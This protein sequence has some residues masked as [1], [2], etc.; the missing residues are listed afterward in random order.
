MRPYSQD[1]RDRVLAA[2]D[3]GLATRVV[4]TRFSVRESWVRRLKQRRAATG[5]I[6]PRPF[7]QGRVPFHRR[8]ETAIRAA[9]A[10]R[11]HRTLAELR[12]HLGVRV[13]LSTLWSALQ[14]LGLS[15][16]KSRSTR[17]STPGPMS[18]PPASNGGGASRRSTR[19]GSSS[20]TKPGPR[21]A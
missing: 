8:Q 19:S 16:K 20:S 17:R 4:A 2:V 14:A 3:G 13:Q 9:V 18:P 15:W 6:T 5:E 21:P 7:G 10:E 1:L 12:T 11:P